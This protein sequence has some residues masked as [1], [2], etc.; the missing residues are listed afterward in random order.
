MKKVPALI[1]SLQSNCDLEFD[2]GLYFLSSQEWVHP[3]TLCYDITWHYMTD[4]MYV[5][6][7][8]TEHD[9]YSI[10]ISLEFLY[11]DST[12]SHCKDRHANTHDSVSCRLMVLNVLLFSNIHLRGNGLWGRLRTSSSS[13]ILGKVLH[14]H[15]M[16]D[17]RL[18][19]T[20]LITI[21]S[22]TNQQDLIFV[23]H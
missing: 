6:S 1:Q 9:L 14:S 22:P 8:V 13:N 21:L 23:C 11:N 19:K 2:H 15:V 17:K 20:T 16:L 18:N 5:Y 7:G 12:A 10:K 4:F 3:L